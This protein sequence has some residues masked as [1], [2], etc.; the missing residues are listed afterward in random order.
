MGR[1]F[2]K[3]FL[4]FWLTLT[5]AVCGTGI[6][7]VWLQSRAD[8]D[9]KRLLEIGTRQMLATDM[10]ASTLRNGGIDAL[11]QWMTE[12]SIALSRPAPLYVVDASGVDILG[13]AVPA[14]ALS[15]A[16]EITSSNTPSRGARLITATNGEKYLFFIPFGATPPSALKSAPPA[17]V[18]IIMGLITSITVSV[19]L[20]YYLTRPIRSLRWAFNAVASGRLDTRVVP[21]MGRRRDEIADLGEYF[22]SMVNQL[23]LLMSGHK[24]LL[25]DISHEL[26][27][28]LA[29]LQAAVGLL[30]QD[31]KRLDLEPT[32]DRIE[33]ETARLDEMIGEVLTLARLESGSLRIGTEIVYMADLVAGIVADARFE[34]EVSNK[35]VVFHCEE[36]ASI[37]GRSDLLHQAIE[38]VVRNAVKYTPEGTTV[39]ISLRVETDP[40]RVCIIVADAGPGILSA[41]VEHV[42]EPFYRGSSGLKA[43]G[44]GLGLAIAHGAVMAH[45]GSIAARNAIKGGLI[46]EIKLPLH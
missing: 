12:V 22:D 2:W 15:R 6:T 38:N 28:P 4:A 3:L 1:L 35:K 31:P 30:R 14:D 26:R 34:A 25:H 17:W 21:R 24:Q 18:F 16:R 7:T 33:K 8:G 40:A 39:D 44:F 32:L 42:F 36:D 10:A 5:V 45:G 9:D 43:E 27:S 13:R 29:R 37:S 23:Q 41:D 20:A 19:V 11:K 46:V